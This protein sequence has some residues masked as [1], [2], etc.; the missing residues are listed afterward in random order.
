[1]GAAMTPNEAS[2]LLR[3][4]RTLPFRL[5]G[6]E[7]NAIKVAKFLHN[8]PKVKQVNFPGIETH[9]DYHLGKSQ[10]S[11]YSGLMSFELNEA[12]FNDVNGVIKKMKV[13]KI[14]VS[15]GSFE[16]LI[17]SPNLGNN[18]G[19]LVKEHIDP[20]TIRLAVGLENANALI[21]DLEQA[22]SE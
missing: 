12:S 14:G 3:G 19:K 20:C 8:H 13:F 22:L 16:S 2:L 21:E 7:E 11:G 17:L 18:E 10:L 6:H 15:W 5:Q 4:L 1:M 9:P